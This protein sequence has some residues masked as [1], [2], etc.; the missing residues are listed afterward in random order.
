MTWIDIA[1]PMMSAAS[2]TL[3]LVHVVT[4]YKQRDL[5]DHLALGLICFGVGV[6]AILEWQM[7]RAQ[8]PDSF[9]MLMRWVLVPFALI[10]V[11]LVAFVRVHFRA[12]RLWLGVLIIAAQLAS[13][14]PNFFTGVNLSFLEVTELHFIRVWH[15]GPI[16]A[17]RGVP[18]PW[19]FL[20]LFTIIALLVF[21]VDAIVTV[22]QRKQPSERRRAIFICGSMG[23]FLL[24][25]LLSSLAVVRGS[26]RA[27]LIVVPAFIGALIVISY[28]LGASVLQSALLSRQ[29]V[30]A[31]SNLRDSKNRMDL[32][33]MA[34]GVGLWTWDIEQGQ[35]WYSEP[36]LRMLGFAADERVDQA[37]FLQSVHPDDRQ[38]VQDALAEATAK[39]GQYRNEYRIVTANAHTRWIA[40]RGQVEF[41][42]NHVPLRV[43][44][45]VADITE[46]GQAEENLRVLVEASPTALLMVDTSGSITLVNG[47]AESV[48]GYSRTEL[49]GMNVDALVPTR[50]RDWHVGDRA[51]YAA[52]PIVRPMGV[53]RELFARRKNGTEV[54]VEIRLSPIRN[55]QGL[56]VLASILDVSARKRTERELA[57]QRDELAHL[58][59]VVMLAELSGSLAH[60]LNQ[61]MTAVLSNAQ[62]ALRFL[63][64]SPPNLD[65]VRESLTSIV[66][67]DK[68]AGEVIRRLRAMLRKEPAEHK[69][70]DINDV[71]LDVLRII[72]SDLL[73]RN[74][75]MVLELAP[76]LPRVEGDRVQ[77]QQVLLNL[78][79]NAT[80]AMESVAKGRQ[81]KL[82]TLLTEANDVQVSVVDAGC[83]IP[84][85]DLELIFSPFVTSKAGGMG[86]GLA[87]CT[88]IVQTHRGRIWAS[89]NASGGATVHFSI[90]A[91]GEPAR[92]S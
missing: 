43:R 90:P 26:V 56:F 59:R 84:A 46:R 57:V 60:E 92:R 71:V 76:V 8:T 28:D 35:S 20:G 13:L 42:K 58:S 80:D 23:L 69:R 55:E 44:G 87:V 61:P 51:A 81:I 40:A 14:I 88:S 3:A 72:R 24:F 48:F 29:L 45:I 25:I 4:W 49:L 33:V 37:R 54:P 83:G 73:N 38:S 64:H 31:E 32:T 70:L 82:H 30:L 67:N 19:M 52:D 74:V 9:A 11:G 5:A 7:M 36:G 77:L 53:D 22:W 89:N 78:V 85:D 15:G 1:W 50:Y 86:L 91:I 18:N 75:D 66:E 34:A 47:Q 63:A 68:R 17:P 27:P 2:L 21:L 65:E 41:D 16:A 39:E 10:F 6:I 62:A 79:M 12:G